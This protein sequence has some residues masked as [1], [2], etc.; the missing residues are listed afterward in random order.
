MK[1]PNFSTI[2]PAKSEV[3]GTVEAWKREAEKSR[4]EK[5]EDLL[6]ETNE[7]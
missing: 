2:N 7:Q 4:W 1:K 3:K 5:H 6:F